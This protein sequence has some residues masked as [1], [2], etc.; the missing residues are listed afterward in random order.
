M[1]TT[2]PQLGS[3]R[4]RIQRRPSL[5]HGA[6]PYPEDV[7]RQDLVLCKLTILIFFMMLS[8]AHPRPQPKSPWRQPSRNGEERI[9]QDAVCNRRK[10]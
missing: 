3:D 6:T 1:G 8:D 2:K 7:A 9:R 10:T 5:D 4:S